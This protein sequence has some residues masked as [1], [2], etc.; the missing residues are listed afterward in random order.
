MRYHRRDVVDRAIDLLDEVGLEGL[1]M[2]RLAADLGVRPSALYH[3][4]ASRH[5][6]LGAVADE[7]LER[8]R[9]PLEVVGWQD[10]LRL[11]CLELRDVLGARRDAAPLMAAARAAGTGAG[12]PVRRMRAALAFAGADPELERV[13]AETLF[14]FVLGHVAAESDEA[15]FPLGLALVLEGLAARLG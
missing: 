3:H 4:V 6:L 14:R 2:R 1:S 13:G 5:E 10:E 15:D 12:E 7:I 8:G 11:V 9:R